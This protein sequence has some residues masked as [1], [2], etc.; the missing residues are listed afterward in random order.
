MPT[1]PKRTPVKK[2]RDLD[3]GKVAGN[4]P[5]GCGQ[6]L[7]LGQGGHVTCSFLKCP[8][9]DAVSVILHDDAKENEH[10][11]EVSGNT[12]SVLHPLWE[13][14]DQRILECDLHAWLKQQS[15]NLPPLE[16]GTYRYTYDEGCHTWRFL[17]SVE[18]N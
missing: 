4:C 8:A 11:V 16:D 5:M 1:T 9:P 13:R 10:V 17:N 7:F 18:D 15:E 3:P 6:T 12:V 2:S 14:I